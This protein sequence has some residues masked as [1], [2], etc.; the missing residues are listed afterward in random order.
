MFKDCLETD[1]HHMTSQAL[2]ILID[3][4][5]DCAFFIPFFRSFFKSLNFNNSG[6]GNNIKKQ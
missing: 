3:F 6:A 1:V 4:I 5:Q 2:S